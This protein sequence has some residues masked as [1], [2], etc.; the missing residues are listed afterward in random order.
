MNERF[1][2]CLGFV[3]RWEGGYSDGTGK[4][5]ADRGGAT[6]R[7]ITQKVFDEYRVRKGLPRQPVSGISGDEVRSIYHGSYWTPIHGD[8]LPM[9]IDLV[10]FDSAVNCGVKQAVRFLQRALN[11]PDD[12]IFGPVTEHSLETTIYP[13]EDIAT[14]VIEQRDT[15]YEKLILNDSR[16]AIFA[17]G[18]ER[19]LN[20]LRDAL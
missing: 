20:A 17:K 5:S 18:W 13:P 10:L 6:N 16:Q 8:D 9:P 4:N 3:L 19:R 12:G 15:F 7:G 1:E 14:R 11:I 2:E